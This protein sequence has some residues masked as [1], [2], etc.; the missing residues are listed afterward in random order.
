MKAL[1]KM[2][3][4]DKGELITRLFPE[5]VKDLQETVKRQCEYFKQNE[6]SIRGGWKKNAK[7]S[8]EFWYQLVEVANSNIKNYGKAV[9]GKPS[10]YGNLLYTEQNA[11]FTIYCLI[12]YSYSNECS[13]ELKQVIHLLFGSKRILKTTLKGN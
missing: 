1:S 6:L 5:K 9:Y 2:T 4:L 12:E 7:F 10:R 13:I 8:A 11:I 3:N